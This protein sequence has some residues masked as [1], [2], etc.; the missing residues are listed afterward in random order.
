[1]T[2]TVVLITIK[3]G[4]SDRVADTLKKI[5]GVEKVLIV[6]GPYDIIILAEL[7][8]RSEYKPFVNAIHEIDDITRT[9]TCLAI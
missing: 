1:M 3:V 9:E 8:K 5:K 4:S 7:E 2:D 6:T